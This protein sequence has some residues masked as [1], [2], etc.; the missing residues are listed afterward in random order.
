MRRRGGRREGGRK[1]GRKGK[2][3]LTEPCCK[4]EKEAKAQGEHGAA[5]SSSYSWDPSCF[6]WHGCA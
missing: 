1:E 5:S 3:Y 4:G 2:T 6:W